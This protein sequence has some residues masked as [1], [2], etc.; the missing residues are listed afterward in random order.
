M[1]FDFYREENSDKAVFSSEYMILIEGKLGLSRAALPELFKVC[2][3][4]IKTFRGHYKPF[5]MTEPMYFSLQD[6]NLLLNKN[7]LFPLKDL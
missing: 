6:D 3:P 2:K 1:I 5:N 7:P 4:L